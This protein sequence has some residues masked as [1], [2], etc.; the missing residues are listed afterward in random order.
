MDSRLMTVCLEYLVL[1]FRNHSSR[2][3]S[4]ISNAPTA[5]LTGLLETGGQLLLA[6]PDRFDFFGFDP[7]VAEI[8]LKLLRTLVNELIDIGGEKIYTPL[9]LLCIESTP[10]TTPAK[11][12]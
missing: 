1:A 10:V 7:L 11:G 3:R 12:N 8:E 5:V 4:A 9:A 6:G 2:V